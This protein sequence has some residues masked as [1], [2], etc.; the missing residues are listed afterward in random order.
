MMS[1][2]LP[3]VLQADKGNSIS[4][5]RALKQIRYLLDLVDC[6]IGT[7]IIDQVQASVDDVETMLAA[8]NRD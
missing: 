8:I 2:Q 5:E 3:S 6:D 4:M 1:R 7:G